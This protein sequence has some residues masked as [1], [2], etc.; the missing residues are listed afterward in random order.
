MSYIHRTNPLFPQRLAELT[1]TDAVE[2]IYTSGRGALLYGDVRRP[3]IAIV[4]SRAC[5]KY[6]EHLAMSLTETLV[7]NYGAIIV[8]GL[9]YGIDGAAHRAALAA[10]GDTIAVMAGGLDRLYPSGHISM[11]ERIREVGVLVSEYPEGMA[12]TKSSFLQRNRIIAGLA[13]VVVVVEAARR[14]G[15]LNAASH[16]VRFGRPVGAVP[17][18]VTSVASAGCHMLIQSGDARLVTT[19]EEIMALVH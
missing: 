3:R 19:A 17:G 1:G 11:G 4:G 5:T 6:G 12:A 7:R 10:R 13:D 16:A 18:P 15:S 8:S 2:G 14:G 9:A